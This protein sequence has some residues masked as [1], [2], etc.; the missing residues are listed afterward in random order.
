MTL[1]N[2]ACVFTVCPKVLKQLKKSSRES[3]KYFLVG[4]FWDTSNPKDQTSR[5]IKESNWING[6]EDKFIEE[7][8]N[9]NKTQEPSQ[10]AF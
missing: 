9:R 4:A 8:K 3:K 1:S 6:Y 2:E 5:F 10:L 7:V